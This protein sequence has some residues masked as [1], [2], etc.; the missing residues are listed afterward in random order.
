MIEQVRT[1][2]SNE[3][4]VVLKSP[5]LLLMLLRVYSAL[6][7]N[8][9]APRACEKCQ[10]GYYEQLRIDGIMKAELQEKINARTCVPAWAGRMYSTKVFEFLI[11]SLM[12]DEK[13]IELLKLGA[14]KE[15]DFKVLPAGYQKKINFVDSEAEKKPV[16]VVK[17]GRKPNK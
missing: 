4:G 13:A 14:L 15:S 3:V 7:L 10:R 8:G 12:H 1:I 6:Y 17:R 5:D 9:E 2:L 11:P 16:E